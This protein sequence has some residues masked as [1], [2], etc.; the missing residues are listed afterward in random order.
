MKYDKLNQPKARL[1][2]FIKPGSKKKA[3]ATAAELGVT[4]SKL[5]ENLVEGA[6]VGRKM[7]EDQT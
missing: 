4:V 6:A 3:K 5:F 2:L 7:Q 1:T